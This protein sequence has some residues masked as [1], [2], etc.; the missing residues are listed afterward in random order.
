MRKS[1]TCALAA[2]L[3]TA[4]IPAYAA[5]PSGGDTG[6]TAVQKDKDTSPASPA[7]KDD[8]QT[9]KV[10]ILGPDGLSAFPNPYDNPGPRMIS[11][12]WAMRT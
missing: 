3:L 9:A 10:I 1:L 7:T 8:D 12:A 6:Q 2:A 11:D 4:A 5:D